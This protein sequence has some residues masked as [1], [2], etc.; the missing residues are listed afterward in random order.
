MAPAASAARG[1]SS[2]SSQLGLACP[3]DGAPSVTSARVGVC[4]R[5]L[6]GV[7]AMTCFNLK[8]TLLVFMLGTCIGLSSA[9]VRAEDAGPIPPGE[10]EEP[11]PGKPGPG[12][13]IE[14]ETPFITGITSFLAGRIRD[15]T[16]SEEIP[17]AVVRARFVFD[18]GVEPP[19]SPSDLVMVILTAE[20]YEPRVI[21]E[22]TQL[23][24]SLLFVQTVYIIPLDPVVCLV[25]ISKPGR[26]EHC[27]WEYVLGESREEEGKPVQVRVTIRHC[28]NGVWNT[29]FSAFLDRS[30]NPPSGPCT[31]CT[32]RL[33]R[34][35]LQFTTKKD[36]R[37]TVW[38]HIVYH[39]QADGKFAA[40]WYE[41][42]SVANRPP[43]GKCT[44]GQ[45]VIVCT[46]KEEGGRKI[47][48]QTLY[49]CSPA[50]T[51]EP[52]GSRIVP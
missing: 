33:Q 36:G 26:C 29:V 32:Y 13:E 47:E 40:V 42:P 52:V 18:E 43:D 19:Y 41:I 20:G 25:P 6:K 46:V 9:G 1:D 16:T 30:P 31:F 21:T 45:L 12:G 11:I 15:C 38:R 4:V 51:W 49:K 7:V 5:L 37:I 34:E 28:D 48:T 22:F 3:F 50:G 17:P 23:N 8:Q 14:Y 2:C 35:I 24:I 39:C 27:T 10:L 44:P